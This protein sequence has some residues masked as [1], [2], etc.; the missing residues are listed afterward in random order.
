MSAHMYDIKTPLIK[1]T[2]LYFQY[3]TVIIAPVWIKLLMPDILK[4]SIFIGFYR[5]E[6]E[7]QSVS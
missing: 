7:P 1:F 3:L 2:S 4:I 6:I 5:K